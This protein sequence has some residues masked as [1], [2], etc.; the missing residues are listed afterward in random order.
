[1]QKDFQHRIDDL[2]LDISESAS[3]I[4]QSL[5][6]VALKQFEMADEV[7]SYVNTRIKEA[8]TQIDDL[9]WRPAIEKGYEL[10]SHEI[11]AEY[12]EQVVQVAQRI[13]YRE[14]FVF[15]RSNRRKRLQCLLK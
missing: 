4:V 12:F 9:S 13:P 7:M 2:E 10:Y 6:G 1:M 14:V 15:S 3:S 5:E 8:Q 11:D